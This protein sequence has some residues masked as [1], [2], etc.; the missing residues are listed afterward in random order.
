MGAAIVERCLDLRV[1]AS[2][3][4]FA[5]DEVAI[6]ALWALDERGVRVPEEMAII[7]FD[8]LPTAAYARVPLTSVAQPAREVGSQLAQLLMGGLKDPKRI[9][10]CQI[11]LPARLVVR[12]SCGASL[13]EKGRVTNA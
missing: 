10:G 1:P 2:A 6:G 3:I 4:L 11:V 5:D 13:R 7:G 9:E 12:K 8:D